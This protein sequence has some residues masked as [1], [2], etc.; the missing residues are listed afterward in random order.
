MQFLRYTLLTSNF[1]LDRC[2]TK[3]LNIKCKNRSDNQ[4]YIF[5]GK[6]LLRQVLAQPLNI[7]VL[8]KIKIYLWKQFSQQHC[9]HQKF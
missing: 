1:N 9:Q 2:I 6:F 7:F 4:F 5:D 8:N 3:Y